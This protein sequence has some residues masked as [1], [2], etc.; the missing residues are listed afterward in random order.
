MNTE[1]VHWLGG[2]GTSCLSMALVCTF[3]SPQAIMTCLGNTEV[4]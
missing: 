1:A 4:A 2:K 3:S